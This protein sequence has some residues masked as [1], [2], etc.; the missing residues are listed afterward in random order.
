MLKRRKVL[1]RGG[2]ALLTGVAVGGCV[3]NGGGDETGRETITTRTTKGAGTTPTRDDEETVDAPDKLRFILSNYAKQNT[4]HSLERHLSKEIDTTVTLDKEQ[5]YLTWVDRFQHDRGEVGETLAVIA[6]PAHERD[7]VE[8]VLDR[9]HK[10]HGYTHGSALVTR[11]DSS[12]HSVTDLR[13]GTITLGNDLNLA[14]TIYPLQMIDAAGLDTGRLPRGNGEKADFNPYWLRDPTQYGKEALEVLRN[15][16][17]VDAAGVAE[18]I[19]RRDGAPTDGL[20]I[21]DSKGGIPS[22]PVVVRHDLDTGKRDAIVDAFLTAP[23]EVFEEFWFRAVREAQTERY[24]EK[25]VKPLEDLNIGTGFIA[26]DN[27]P[28]WVTQRGLDISSATDRLL[29]ASENG[30]GLIDLDGQ[31]TNTETLGPMSEITI[32]SGRTDLESNAVASTTIELSPQ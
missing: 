31:D 19:V 30:P 32:R 5:T 24:H 29:P 13:G 8:I 1:T 12:I 14:S 2:E 9:E 17:S 10:Q 21:L 7:E 6:A 25:V 16:T 11:A 28:D 3:D 27:L 20:R 26:K 22:P 15:D 18:F 23:P 4:Y